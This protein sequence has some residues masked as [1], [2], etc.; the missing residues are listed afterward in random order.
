M[1]YRKFVGETFNCAVR[2][3][4]YTKN[5]CGKAWLDNYLNTLTKKDAQ[6][7]VEECCS[8]SYRFGD[9]NTTTTSILM[10]IFALIRSRRFF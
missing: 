8:S 4:E 5:V 10:P 6:K 2:D 3:S 1:L 9:G 7:V